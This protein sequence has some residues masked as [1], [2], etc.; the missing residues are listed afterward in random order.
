MFVLQDPAKFGAYDQNR[1][2]LVDAPEYARG[3]AIT[4]HQCKLHIQFCSSLIIYLFSY[5]F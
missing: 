2:G 3:E 5:L 4:E 1:D